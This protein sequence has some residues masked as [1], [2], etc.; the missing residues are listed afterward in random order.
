MKE[1][2]FKVTPKYY[3]LKTYDWG[4]NQNINNMEIFRFLSVDMIFLANLQ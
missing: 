3:F 4:Y 2:Q 1:V